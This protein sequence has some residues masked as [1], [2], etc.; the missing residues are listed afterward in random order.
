VKNRV[1]FLSRNDG[2]IHQCEFCGTRLPLNSEGH[3]RELRNWRCAGCDGFYRAVLSSSYD[4]EGLRNVRPEAFPI[5][6]SQIPKPSAELNQHATDLNLLEATGTEKR[7]AFRHLAVMPV[8]AQPM[9]AMLHLAGGPFA[10]VSRNLSTNGIC[11]LHTRAVTEKFLGIE[12]AGPHGEMIQVLLHVLRCRSRGPFQDVAGEF[13]TKMYYPSA[14]TENP[15][16]EATTA[17]QGSP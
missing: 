7:G 2:Q 13:I 17:G 1:L 8:I 15:H 9:D 6:H 5:D 11:L 14:D 12:L 3:D 16:V 10:A 4:L